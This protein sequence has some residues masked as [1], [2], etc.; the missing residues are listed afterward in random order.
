MQF[1]E[2]LEK[3]LGQFPKGCPINFMPEKLWQKKNAS[4]VLQKQANPFV[5]F[6]EG[7]ALVV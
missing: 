6:G 3:R 1:Q 2:V 4:I 5:H 7:K